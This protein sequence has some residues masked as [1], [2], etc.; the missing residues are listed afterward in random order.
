MDSVSGSPRSGSGFC[1]PLPVP[2]MTAIPP[3][4]LTLLHCTVQTWR[5]IWTRSK[6]SVFHKL[7]LLDYSPA[8][9]SWPCIAD[10]VPPSTAA[11]LTEKALRFADCR[12]AF[13]MLQQQG[14]QADRPGFAAACAGRDGRG[15]GPARGAALLCPARAAAQRAAAAGRRCRPPRPPARPGQRRQRAAAEGRSAGGRTAASPLLLVAL[16]R[17]LSLTRPARLC[18]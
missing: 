12:G 13:S 15:R 6:T 10:A 18:A 11:R 5:V 7:P 17:L 1:R 16:A 3:D 9:C 8:C 2:T 4:G 14:S